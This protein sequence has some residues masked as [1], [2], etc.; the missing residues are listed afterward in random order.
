MRNA[1]AASCVVLLLASIPGPV[2]AQ[3]WDPGPSGAPPQLQVQ[4]RQ[5]L[6]FGTVLPGVSVTVS[7]L[8]PE[9]GL[10]RVF[11]HKRTQVTLQFVNLPAFINS[12]GNTM[13]LGFGG[14]SAT[15]AADGGSPQAF[16]PGQPVSLSFP[17]QARPRWLDVRLGGTLS[18][19]DTQPAGAYQGTVT[20]D[21][22]DPGS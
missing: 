17:P 20:L 22:F 5:D 19:A 12:G 4:P 7:P 6:Q 8:D 14:G 9:A 13:A 11:L 1:L 10:W 18:P 2:A 15:W 21:V 16:D 3:R